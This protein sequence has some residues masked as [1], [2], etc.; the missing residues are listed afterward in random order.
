MSLS[1]FIPSPPLPFALLPCFLLPPFPPLLLLFHLLPSITKLFDFSRSLLL[2]PQD[3][4]KLLEKDFCSS[5]SMTMQLSKSQ[6]PSLW[7]NPM[8]SSQ[9]LTYLL[10]TC[11]TFPGG[12][13]AKNS[14]ANAGDVGSIPGSGR[15]SGGRHDTQLQYS[16]LGNPM[17]RGAWQATVHG[18]TESQTQLSN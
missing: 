11:P 15:S 14:P 12:S 5:H 6:T 9:P 16:C 13:V 2:H 4:L 8:N 18:V 10:L 3:F 1:S 7:L 17:D